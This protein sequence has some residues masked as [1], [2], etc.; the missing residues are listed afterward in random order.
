MTYGG[1]LLRFLLVPILLL[2]GV[3]WHD[4][5]RRRL[6]PSL[7]AAAPAAVVAALAVVAV[8]YTTPWDNYLVATNVWSYDPTLVWGITLGYVPLEEYLF[9]VLQ[10][11]MVG[12]WLLTLSRRLPPGD[13]LRRPNRARAAG[14]GGAG[15]LW[16][17]SVGVLIAGWQPGR[18]LGLLLAWAL[19]PVMLQLGVG[20]DILWGHRAHVLVA[21]VS[22]TLYLSLVDA[23][24]IADGT[25]TITPA[26]SL[27]V[28]ILGVLPVEEL[29]FFLITNTL[30]VFGALLALA[31]ATW[32]R[33]PFGMLH[34]AI[35]ASQ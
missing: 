16:M 10:T 24:A 26:Y 5:G 15:V 30:I 34:Q 11:V 22:A 3:T 21:I 12:L 8:T 1:F 23:F 18:Y 7:R 17:L 27:E 29:I 31:R 25:W 6:P 9:F 33:V 14:V 19:P 4:A 2:A 35:G 32:Q 20:G 13:E 28:Y